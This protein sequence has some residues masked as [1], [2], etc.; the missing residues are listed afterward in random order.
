MKRS[1]KRSNSSVIGALL[2]KGEAYGDTL[3]KHQ[4]KTQAE[5]KDVQL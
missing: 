2:I 5:M 3:R 4:V 1:F